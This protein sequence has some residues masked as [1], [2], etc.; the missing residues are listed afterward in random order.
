MKICLRIQQ[1]RTRSSK[2][3]NF[4]LFGTTMKLDKKKRN[5]FARKTHYRNVFFPYKTSTIITRQLRHE[6]PV[7]FFVYDE[8][9]FQETLKTN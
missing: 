1:S 5:F 2:K 8:F 3:R 6:K 7:L 4:F 9:F